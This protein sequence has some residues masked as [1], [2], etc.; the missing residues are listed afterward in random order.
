M[1]IQLGK[2]TGQRRNVAKVDGYVDELRT[3][4]IER[5]KRTK[6]MSIGNVIDQNGILS[7][8]NF[9]ASVLFPFFFLISFLIVRSRRVSIPC[10]LLC[11]FLRRRAC[12][13]VCVDVC[14]C[15]F[16]FIMHGFGESDASRSP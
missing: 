14:V 15:G 11:E 4:R 7:R 2:C 13:C 10:Y 1:S 12:V 5:T 8:D 6:K 3:T 16:A 9:R